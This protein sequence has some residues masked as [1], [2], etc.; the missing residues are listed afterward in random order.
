MKLLAISFRQLV[1]PAPA[2]VR[3]RNRILLEPFAVRVIVKILARLA[4][5][6]QN[7]E[8]NAMSFSSRILGAGGSL[9]GSQHSD[10]NYAYQGQHGG[11]EDVRANGTF[12][13]AC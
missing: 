6:V 8:V 5:R 2:G 7:R 3:S 9:S 13:L 11:D 4:R 12:R 10:G 1:E